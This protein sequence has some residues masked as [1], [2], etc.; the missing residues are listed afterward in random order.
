VT[1][2]IEHIIMRVFRGDQDDSSRSLLSVE[3]SPSS[4][5]VISLT[6]PPTDILRRAGHPLP[7]ATTD[8]VLLLLMMMMMNWCQP[9]LFVRWRSC[10]IANKSMC[11]DVYT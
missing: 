7:L 2:D 3:L 5:V 4:V 1:K 9:I 11:S 6:T 10:S 8:S